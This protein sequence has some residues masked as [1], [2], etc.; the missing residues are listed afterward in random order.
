[1]GAMSR[2]VRV[3]S[4]ESEDISLADTERPPPRSPVACARC[5]GTGREPCGMACHDCLGFGVIYGGAA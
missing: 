2:E 1:M 4:D 3:Q 5:E